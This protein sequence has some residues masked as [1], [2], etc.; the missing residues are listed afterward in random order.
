MLHVPVLIKKKGKII[1][2]ASKLLSHCAN[3]CLM[4]DDNQ[5]INRG[6]DS[7]NAPIEAA[8]RRLPPEYSLLQQKL[9]SGVYTFRVVTQRSFDWVVSP[10][11]S[12]NRW[13]V[14]AGESSATSPG[15]FVPVFLARRTNLSPNVPHNKRQNPGQPVPLFLGLIPLHLGVLIRLGPPIGVPR[16][17]TG[18]AIQCLFAGCD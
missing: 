18:G 13:S 10:C 15:S 6:L 11:H 14:Q 1:C 17:P 3:R 5:M 12:R 4:R 7:G 9:H 16:Q 8:L 2:I